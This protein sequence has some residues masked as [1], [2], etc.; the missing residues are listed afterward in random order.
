[1]ADSADRPTPKKPVDN[2]SR[3][4]SSEWQKSN[5]E[6]I[7]ALNRCTERYGLFSDQFRKF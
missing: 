6:A 2:T 3:S 7:A 4:T 5:R 1:M